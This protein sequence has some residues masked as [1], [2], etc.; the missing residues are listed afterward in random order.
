MNKKII[1]PIS[2]EEMEQLRIGEVFNWTFPTEENEMI[3]III[4]L[5]DN[6]E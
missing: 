6:N 3:D 1:V 2:E 5:E 4:K